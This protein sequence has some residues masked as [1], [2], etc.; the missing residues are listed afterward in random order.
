[1]HAW[2]AYLWCLAVGISFVGYGLAL[3]R[4]L[5]KDGQGWLTATA[6]GIGVLTFLLSLMNLLG[7]IS[8]MPLLILVLIGDFLFL[9]VKKPHGRAFTQAG[10]AAKSGVALKL[11]AWAALVLVGCSA[12][13]GLHSRI[14]NYFDD[15]QAYFAY[16][17]EALQKGSLQ[18]QPFSERRIN[19]SLGA[20][21]LLDAVMTVDGDVRSIGFL[22]RTLGYILYA[23][24]IWIVGRKLDL[25]FGNKGLLLGLLVILPIVQVNAAPVYLQSG[26]AISLLLVM[27]EATKKQGADWRS[28]VLWGLIASVLCLTKSNGIVFVL[29]LVAIFVIFHSIRM[30]SFGQTQNSVVA[31]VTVLV[32]AL[33]WMLQQHRN[34]GTYLSPLLGLG[35]H[36]SHWGIVPLPRQTATLPVIAIVVLPDVGVL[37]VA[38]FLAWKLRSHNRSFDASLMTFILA[39]LVATPIIAFSTAG[40]AVDRFTFPFQVPALIIVAALVLASPLSDL[41]R[42]SWR[43][44]AQVFL[45]FWILA[46]VAILGKHH[47]SYSRS[48][49]HMED[50]F[51]G[52]VRE[53]L[54]DEL[55]LDDHTMLAEEQR[56]RTAQNTV[57]AGAEIME[58]T[59]YAY[60]YDF[61]RNRVF[62]ADYPGLAGWAPGIPVGKGP[63]PVRD[64]LLSHN[65]HYF[66][67][68]RRLTYNNEDI[69]EF[70]RSPIL[71]ASLHDMISHNVHHEIFPWS[72]MEWMVSRDV[73]HNL[74]LIADSSTRLYDDG[75]LVVVRV[76]PEH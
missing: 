23:A 2:I 46:I 49:H 12:L 56:A 43:G 74:L 9:V 8:W 36:A 73:R 61:R 15:T 51:A 64:Y 37:L 25:S 54:F 26:I 38:A 59:L 67:C 34:E 48:L 18:P 39:T 53:P 11:I 69:G 66:V 40:E 47:A 28:G 62:I 63:E 41:Q 75:T 24:A 19:T 14:A 70:L 35:F 42:K 31:G 44:A 3:L 13:T 68:D 50:T 57:P 29:F 4:L 55:V 65:L 5:S 71:D 76:K 45:L 7:A 1:M 21:Y 22:D 32:L 16:P 27:H 20:N 72:R 60:P 58:A 17:L 6:S 30:R 52:R 33:P 10:S